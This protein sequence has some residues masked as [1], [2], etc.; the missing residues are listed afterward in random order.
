MD[1]FQIFGALVVAT[2]FGFVGHGFGKGAGYRDANIDLE[3]LKNE[4]DG[5]C[6]RIWEETNDILEENIEDPYLLDKLQKKIG[7]PFDYYEEFLR[8]LNRKVRN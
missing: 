1:D 7:D 8:T 3:E 6:Y 4:V 5:L 2:I